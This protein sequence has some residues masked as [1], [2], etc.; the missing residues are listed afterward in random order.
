MHSN[1]SGFLATTENTQCNNVN[2]TAKNKSAGGNET[3]KRLTFHPIE[4]ARMDSVLNWY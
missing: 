1:H 4:E 2:R 3:Q